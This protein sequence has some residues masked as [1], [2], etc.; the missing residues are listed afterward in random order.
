VEALLVDMQ[1]LGDARRVIQE[2]DR[3]GERM[4]GFGH[5]FY[6]HADPRAE[7]FFEA[8]HAVDPD[9]PDL[10]RLAALAEAMA[11]LGRPAPNVDFGIVALRAALGARRGAGA[12][13][14]AVARCA[15]WVAHALEQVREGQLIRPRARY[16]PPDSP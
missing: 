7:V 13:L 4:P 12:G 2:R 5:P 10:R 15:G 16:R 8:A 9:A 1:A 6:R 11:A 3:R 14:F